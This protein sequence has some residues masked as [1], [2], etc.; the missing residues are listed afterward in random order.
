MSSSKKT[1]P[2][3]IKDM[4]FEKKITL[5]SDAEKAYLSGFID[6]ALL[7]SGK[8]G[9]CKKLSMTSDVKKK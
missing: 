4:P 6:H 7:T 5:L 8:C 2:E 3:T 9:T 1:V